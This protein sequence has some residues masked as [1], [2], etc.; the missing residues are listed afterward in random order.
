LHGRNG[1]GEKE[2]RRLTR[3]AETVDIREW[4]IPIWGCGRGRYT[5][6]RTEA[7]TIMKRSFGEG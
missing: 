4:T 5:G 2:K 6:R 7:V 1:K 3:P